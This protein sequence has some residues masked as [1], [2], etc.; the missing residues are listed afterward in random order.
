MT[1]QDLDGA[2]IRETASG[3]PARVWQHETDHLNGTLIL[4][5]MG[6]VARLASR[7]ILKD[8]TAQWEAQNPGKP[9]APTRRR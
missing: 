2:P 5:R 1:A 6:P 4:D 7:R 9:K 8:L 3:F